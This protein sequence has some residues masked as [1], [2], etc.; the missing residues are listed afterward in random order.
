LIRAKLNV[1]LD[2]KLTLVADVLVLQLIS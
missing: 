2:T 1:L